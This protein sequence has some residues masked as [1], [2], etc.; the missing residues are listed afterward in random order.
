MSAR[1]IA[2]RIASNGRPSACASRAAESA[3]APVST[4]LVDAPQRPAVVA[5]A[6]RLA[7]RP[8]T[9]STRVPRRPRRVA[10]DCG[11][12]HLEPEGRAHVGSALDADLAAHELDQLAADGEPEAGAAVAPRVRAVDLREGAEE[13]AQVLGGDADAGVGDRHAHA[14]RARCARQLDRDRAA[15]RELHG[16]ADEVQQHLAQAPRVAQHAPRHVGAETGRQLEAAVLG[17][18]RQRLDDVVDQLPEV[19]LDRLEAH[20]AEAELREVED[21]VDDL[22]ERVARGAD[23]RRQLALLGLERR[24]HE[25]AGHADDAGHRRP[26]LV[27][28]H[29]QE[30]VLGAARLLGHLARAN[31]LGLDSAAARDLGRQRRVGAGQRAPLGVLDPAPRPRARQPPEEDGQR[32]QRRHHHH[33]DEPAHQRHARRGVLLGAF[34]GAA[35]VADEGP[36]GRIDVRVVGRHRVVDA[37]GVDERELG[38]HGAAVDAPRLERGAD[39]EPGAGQLAEAG[40]DRPL[41]LVDGRARLRLDAGAMDGRPLDGVQRV[42]VGLDARQRLRLAPRRLGLVEQQQQRPAQ[43]RRNDRHEAD[44]PAPAHPGGRWN[45]RRGVG[46]EHA[47]T[48]D[49]TSAPGHARPPPPR[50]AR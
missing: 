5:T 46:L 24:L 47:S 49:P 31:E 22:Q 4:S 40:A 1:R 42:G 15:R 2:I 34:G 45:R 39:V 16:V 38:R 37:A 33:H 41:E 10:G 32:R 35:H 18:R 25:E 27:A 14:T 20:A 44:E 19:V 50:R 12:R 28:H 11:E 17:L 9:T 13:A 3:A 30:L 6:R 48:L 8:S 7:R 23:G 36:E 21:V 26:D 29:R 43:R